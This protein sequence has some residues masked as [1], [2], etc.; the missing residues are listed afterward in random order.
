MDRE[1]EDEMAAHVEMEVRAN[2]QRSLT[3]AAMWEFQRRDAEKAV[4]HVRG[5]R[6]VINRITLTPLPAARDQACR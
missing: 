3:P 5:V 2:M 1:L 6:G 4:R